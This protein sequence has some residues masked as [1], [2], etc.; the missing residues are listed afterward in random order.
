MS[1]QELP[2]GVPIA[3]EG[4][5]ADL[6]ATGLL[7]LI[8]RVVFHPRGFALAL[9]IDDATG[10]AVGWQLHGKATEPW[11]FEAAAEQEK[12]RAVEALLSG[13]GGRS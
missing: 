10:E 4:Q 3:C 8:N 11:T 2:S 5:L 9:K 12:Y 13:T 7:W 1:R 6:S